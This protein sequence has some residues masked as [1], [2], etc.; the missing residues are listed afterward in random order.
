[1]AGTDSYSTPYS[2]IAVSTKLKLVT[3]YS[4]QRDHVLGHIDTFSTRRHRVNHPQ[5][6]P[7]IALSPDNCLPTIGGQRGKFIIQTLLIIASAMFHPLVRYISL[8]SPPSD[9]AIHTTLR[10]PELRIDNAA[11][12]L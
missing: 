4:T 9:Y 6:I 5:P 7:S 11:L 2:C 8:R 12:N 10:E 1:M 3:V